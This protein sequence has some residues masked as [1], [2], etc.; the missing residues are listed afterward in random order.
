M[1]NSLVHVKFLNRG[2]RVHINRGETILDAAKK[3][4][5]YINSPCGGMGLCGKCKVL[6]RSGK[7]EIT[8]EERKFLSSEEL[9]EGF[10]LACKAA[11]ESNLEVETEQEKSGS[12]ILSAGILNGDVNIQ[13]AL[14]VKKVKLSK[15][16]LGSD[17]SYAELLEEMIPG[18]GYDLTILKQLAEITASEDDSFSAVMMDKQ[19]LSLNRESSSQDLYSVCFDIG[20]TTIAGE[21]VNLSTGESVDSVSAGNA[22]GGYGADVL[23]RI[24]HSSQS[25]ENLREIS[26]VIVRQIDELILQ[27]CRRAEIRPETIYSL[28][29]AGNTTMLQLFA[30]INCS[31]LGKIPFVNVLGRGTLVK[32]KEIGLN[33]LFSEG[34]VYL[35]PVIG[36]FLGG[37]T[38]ACIAAANINNEKQKLQLLV[39]IGTNGE[40]VLNNYGHITAASTAA[41]PALEGAKISCGMR[42]DTGAID[43]CTLEGEDIKFSSIGSEEPEGICGSGLIDAIA[44]MLRAGVINMMGHFTDKPETLP[45]GIKSRLINNNG[46]MEF[47]LS[48]IGSKRV[49]ITQKDIREFQLAAG[50]IRAG[51]NILLKRCGLKFSQLDEVLLA[52]GFG[53]FLNVENACRAGLLPCESTGC[54]SRISSIGNAAL[55]GVKRILLDSTAKEKLEID[56]REIEHVELSLDTDFQMEFSEAML[57]PQIN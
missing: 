21:L 44:C 27:L 57:F 3:A 30:G 14:F 9:E 25:S 32:A 20:T 12:K 22:Q 37:D 39:D 8:E 16:E 49:A 24:N 55:A 17:K 15:L 18:A 5:V 11:A 35:M 56:C 13:P 31:N 34:D 28:F 33:N 23:S 7:T 6:V 50:A 53:A 36:G 40:I 1:N 19:I 46:Q 41:G 4:G 47:V 38:T 54:A 2:H 26:G 51:I 29:A 48:E 43:E 52:G 45:E 42:A 10:R